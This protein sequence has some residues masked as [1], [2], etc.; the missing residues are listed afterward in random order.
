[1]H[2]LFV[3]TSVTEHKW[4]PIISG[5]LIGSCTNSS[6]EDMSRA[7]SVAQQCLDAIN[8]KNEED[9]LEEATVGMFL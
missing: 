8:G 9:T 2:S 4:P 3:C 7:A 5:A 6:Y 1:M